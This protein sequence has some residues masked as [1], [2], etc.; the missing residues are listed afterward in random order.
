[1]F[2]GGHGELADLRKPSGS[3]I[4]TEVK[5]HDHYAPGGYLLI[6]SDHPYCNAVADQK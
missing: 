2:H 5:H 4:H 3:N 6:S 1:M